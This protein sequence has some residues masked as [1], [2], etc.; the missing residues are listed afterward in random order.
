MDLRK[1][2][3]Q[4]PKKLEFEEDS[5]TDRHGRLVVEPL[6]RGYGITIGNSLRRVMLSSLEGA[7]V[8]N[9]RIPGVLH[10]FDTIVGVREDVMDIILNIKKLRLRLTGAGE[11]TITIKEEGPKEIRASDIQTDGAVDVLSP[12]LLIATVDKNTTFEMEMTVK[13]GRGFVRAEQNKEENRPLDVIAVDSIFT[14]IE[15]AN[16]E[17]EKARVGRSTDYDRL[18]MDITTDGSISPEDAITQAATILSEHVDMFIMNGNCDADED[19]YESDY[20]SEPIDETP[21]FNE[22]LLKSID[23]LE[24]SVRS[25]NCLKNADIN[26][27]ADLVQRNDQEMLRTKSFGR[28]SLNEIKA[29]LKPLGLR[30]GMRI[31]MEAFE[32]AM[33]K[34]QQAAEEE[35]GETDEA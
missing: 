24:L 19:D 15:L 27:I 23:E 3:F 8:T 2:G 28:K 29:I 16:Y 6:E 21:I 20:D 10:E 18:F 31:D 9:I 17:V 13:K 35:E 7:A 1:K 25:H 30:F 5:L 22:H 12:D 34:K 4:L 26:T 33:A 32:E 14:P 11:R